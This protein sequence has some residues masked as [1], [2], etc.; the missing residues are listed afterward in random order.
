MNLT[1][2]AIKRPVSAVLIILALIVF[3][4][5]SIP[6]FNLELQPDMEMPM[7]MVMTIYPGADPESVEELVTKE[8]E[9]AG[10]ILSGVE[11]V[12]SASQENMS[13]V[14][15]SYD[16]GIDLDEAYMD[17]RAALDTASASMPEDAG[18]PIIIELSMDA[19]ATMSLSVTTVGDVDLLKAV[20]DS[21][22]PELE[23]LTGVADVTVSGGQEDYIRVE[24]KEDLLSQYGLTMSSV[25]QYISTV[26]FNIPAGTVKQGTQ[27]ISISS[28]A[29]YKTVQELQKI[30]LVTKSGSVVQ[31]S[32][33]ATVQDSTKSA[34]SISRYNG[35]ENITIDIKKKQSVGTVNVC[36]DVRKVVNRLQK[37]NQAIELQIIYDASGMIV[38]SLTSVGQTLVLGIALS[39][40][41]LFLFFGDFKASLIVGSSM[42]VS[43]L[44]TL[45]L[46][47]A[48]G[49]SMNL[50]TMG[51][52]VIAIGMMVD[53]SIVVLESCFRKREDG[54]H[55]KDAASVGAKIV[56]SSIIAS[57]I[58][59][60]VVYF[61]LSVMQGISG[62]MFSQLGFTIIFAMLSS[63]I[64]AMTLIPL[65]FFKF[66]PVEKKELLTNRILDKVSNIYAKV[67]RKILYKKKTVVVIS[68][69]LL[70]GAFAL[71]AV[72]NVELI[73]V[74]D[75]GAASISV[76]FRSGTTLE[77]MDTQMQSLEDIVSAHPDVENYSLTISGS[78]AT[79][80]AYLKDDREMRTSEV[81]EQWNREA[82]DFTNMDISI[83]SSGS[84]MNGAFGSGVDINL[85]GLDRE[86]LKAASKQVEEMMRAVPG[87]MKVTS[88]ASE[89]TT[90]AQIIVD[91]L[92]AMNVGLTPIQVASNI[93]A[94]LSGQKV[95][96]IKDSGKEYEV[97]LEYPK[98][99]YENM[100]DLS[101]IML[102]T[103][104]NTMVPLMDIAA[105]EYTDAPESISRVDN[106]YQITVSANTTEAAKYTARTEIQEKAAKLVFPEG[107]GLTESMMDEMMNEE[108]GALGNAILTAVFLVFLVMAM[109]FES[110]RYSFM[111]MMCVP[112]SLIGSFLLLFLTNST[113]SMISLMGF[114]MLVGIV[115]NNGIL[116][117][118]TTNQLREKMFVEEA[119][120]QT[121][122]LRLRPILMTTLTTILSMIPLGLG[123]GE[124]G[125]LMQGMALVIIGGLVASTI[126]TLLLLP[127]IYLIIYDRA[128][129]KELKRQER[130]E[131]RKELK[132]KVLREK[133]GKNEKKDEK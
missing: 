24:L 43:L 2:L 4:L 118:D 33:V 122:R 70:A 29:S 89:T 60:I 57:T 1:K 105:V 53:N 74:V 52:L 6:Q 110:P 128:K 96:T 20:E 62:Q 10:A 103:P 97:R 50:V 54:L 46:M 80:S 51:A 3:G 7:L 72:I 104:Y 44:T 131:K 79:L 15:F 21:I 64:S 94:I 125:V 31:L 27:D 129:G 111:V 41:V 100:N 22:V 78:T 77:A 5:S 93:N 18:T 42:P 92:K 82:K 68:V 116:Y 39:M 40:F 56:T 123:I 109:Q 75:E 99:Q 48:M 30:P 86:S 14:M 32:D 59:T 11:S 124:G 87:V 63:L 69:L 121:G 34:E 61:P 9:S 132:E 119:L 102:A 112:F 120:I 113:L 114:L 23:V 67:L 88:T 115:V 58:T 84:G 106:L 117:V 107:V 8:I 108:F 71:L 65:F 95:L 81:I 85:S 36:N 49:F 83:I 101:N 76:D 38:T 91:P 45:I 98:G 13:M 35:Q 26:D 25:A 16:Y 19:S 66:R 17:L 130:K 55:Y 90:K 127:T 73:P 37:E 133:I 126:L 12:Q 47:N 28:S